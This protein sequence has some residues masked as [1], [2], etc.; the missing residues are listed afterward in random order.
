MPVLPGLPD[1]AFL[2]GRA[3][4]TSAEIRAL[5]LCKLGPGPKPLLWDVGAGTGSVS[6]EA[7]LAC[8][9]GRVFS[10]EYKKEALAL[11]T[12]QEP[13]EPVDDGHGSL[14]CGNQ[15]Y[16]CGCVGRYDLTTKVVEKYCNFCIIIRFLR[17]MKSHKALLSKE[18]MQQ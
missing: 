15:G 1:E 3:P 11:L 14:I 12:E 4:M 8:P 18:V 16:E 6:V 9:G 17:A 7:A 5:A 13:I 2:R 10:I